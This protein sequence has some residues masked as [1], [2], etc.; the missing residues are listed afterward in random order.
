MTTEGDAAAISAG[1]AMTIGEISSEGITVTSTGSGSVS[2]FKSDSS[3]SIQKIQ[4][5]QITLES[6]Q[7]DVAVISAPTVNL[8][9]YDGKT[10]VN[11]SGNG[12]ASWID[13]TN[14]VTLTD[15]KGTVE[16]ISSGTGYGVRLQDGGTL[17]V[18]NLSS[19][20]SIIASEDAYG[21]YSSSSLTVEGS[22]TKDFVVSSKFGNASLL[23]GGTVVLNGGTVDGSDQT[24]AMEISGNVIVDGAQ[25]ASAVVANSGMNLDVSGIV[26]AGSFQ[27]IAEGDDVFLHNVTY[28][29]L[30]YS[31]LRNPCQ[32]AQ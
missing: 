14:N 28:F 1:G 31:I 22:L 6:A 30:R 3:V 9:N 20:I 12:E 29:G 11:Y 23:D 18:Q 8:S 5:T 17:S 25:S 13:G 26:A 7:G 24:K 15:A 2:A 10:V 19:S 32:T 27:K 16:I 21:L 4:D